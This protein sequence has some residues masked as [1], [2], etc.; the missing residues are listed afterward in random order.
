RHRRREK[1]VVRGLKHPNICSY[2]GV[3]VDPPRFSLVYKFIDG[4]SLRD[5]LRRRS[6][7]DGPG[8]RGGLLG[9]VDLFRLGKE[10]AEGMR[11]LHE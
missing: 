9:S 11:Y 4:G 6:R 8:G 5:H 7:R 10:T 3:C 2:L 1:E